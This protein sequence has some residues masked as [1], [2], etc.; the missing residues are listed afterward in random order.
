MAGWSHVSQASIRPSRLTRGAATK[1][2]PV[3]S[4][5]TA[6]GRPAAEP[7][8]G[9][10]TISFTT[11]AAVG[12]P[13]GLRPVDR[14]ALP[15][16]DDPGAVGRER[17]V[18]VAQGGGRLRL[19]GQRLRGL[20]PADRPW[21]RGRSGRGAG[22]PSCEEHDRAVADQPGAA[23]VLVHP[24]PGAR[25]R[26]A[27]RR[28]ARRR[29][30][31]RTSCTRPPSSGRSSDQYVTSPSTLAPRPARPRRRRSA[32]AVIGDAHEP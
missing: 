11:S 4:T 24:G 32:P 21:T 16:A 5:T 17:P 20:A 15:H 13:P 19:R 9:T 29:G 30:S 10:A 27:A 18:R 23:A 12:S 31:R 3:A 26:R 14:V 6:S 2:R 8:T 28:R 22:P 25:S 7:S 1:S